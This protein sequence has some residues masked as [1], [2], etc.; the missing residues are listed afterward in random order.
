MPFI[1]YTFTCTGSDVTKPRMSDIA[2]GTADTFGE[3]IYS[4]QI[5]G[6][7]IT[8]QTSRYLDST[9]LSKRPVDLGKHYLGQSRYKGVTKAWDILGQH[10][11][12]LNVPFSFSQRTE[13]C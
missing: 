8:F 11:G 2:T 9:L 3:N 1:P 5:F 13:A 7:N 4:E 10:P 12:L 6:L